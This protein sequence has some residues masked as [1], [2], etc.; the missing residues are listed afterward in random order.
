M[1]ERLINVSGIQI[2]VEIGIIQIV[3]L[4]GVT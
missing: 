4:K 1:G 3:L 2:T